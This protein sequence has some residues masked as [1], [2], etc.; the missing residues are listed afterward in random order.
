MST[1][2][3]SQQS[4]FPN[5]T[6]QKLDELDLLIQKMLELP[7]NPLDPTFLD[8]L[9][10]GKDE[11]SEQ[12]AKENLDQEDFQTPVQESLAESELEIG[13]WEDPCRAAIKPE[14]VAVDLEDTAHFTDSPLETM[15]DLIPDSPGGS[16]FGSMRVTPL[17]TIPAQPVRED[18]P[19][20]SSEE[21]YGVLGWVNR[22]FD[23][24]TTLLGLPGRW[25][26]GPTG[27]PILGWIGTGLLVAALVWGFL[28]WLGWIS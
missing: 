1:S 24:G 9:E 23:R 8:S 25:L 27:R 28:D 14:S 7:V 22:L 13:A 5:P 17:E 19:G 2:G 3:L 18:F 15:G 10:P 6:R 26:R 4:A 16:N 12:S 11:I 21:A 20:G